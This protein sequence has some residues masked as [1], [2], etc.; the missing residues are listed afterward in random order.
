MLKLRHV[1]ENDEEITIT[2]T[3]TPKISALYTYVAFTRLNRYK[4]S[5][6]ITKIQIFCY[7]NVVYRGKMKSWNVLEH[8]TT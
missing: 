6:E 1:D 4:F 8:N 2:T 7:L 3:T 5:N